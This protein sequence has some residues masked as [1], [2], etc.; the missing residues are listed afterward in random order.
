MA[1]RT[2]R[3][4]GELFDGHIHLGSV[5]YWIETMLDAGP[6]TT[7]SLGV[8]GALT[9]PGSGVD[10]DDLWVHGTVVTVRFPEGEW[11]CYLTTADGTLAS[12]GQLMLHPTA[13][14]L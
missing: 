13:S 4:I 7:P 10:L 6:E 8:A 3:G 11:R 12:A 9:A 14:R 5:S 2:F 1:Y